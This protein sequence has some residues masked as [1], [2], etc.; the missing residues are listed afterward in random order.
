MIE[1]KKHNNY[2]LR[3]VFLSN[4]V[5]FLI[6]GTGSFILIHLSWIITTLYLAYIFILEF[7]LIRNHCINCF[8]WGKTCGFGKGRLS[9]WIFKKGDTSKFCQKEMS[10][11]NM[12]PDLLVTLIPLITGIVI[13][14]IKFDFIILIT[15]VLLLLLSTAG[16]GFI[17]GTLI[18]K[19]CKQRELGCPADKLFNKEKKEI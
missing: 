5:S 11:K 10:W 15:V 12:I 3:I 13:I 2:P 18:C 19:Y 17:R 4:T 16:N 8:Y 7:R 14:I 9:S 6:Y 1:P